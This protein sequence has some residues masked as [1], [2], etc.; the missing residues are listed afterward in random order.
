MINKM[1]YKNIIITITLALCVAS[2]SP[3]AAYSSELFMVVSDQSPLRD[4]SA[5]QVKKIFKLR[6]RMW[7]DGMPIQPINMVKEN[8]LRND[9]SQQILRK[10][11]AQ[12]E[13][14]YL[15]MA[16]TGRGQPPHTV[17][18]YDELVSFIRKHQG[19]I[20]YVNQPMNQEGV[21]TLVIKR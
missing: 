10:R 3:Q 18:D 11:P 21:K 7:S 15:K 17:H 14:Y 9:F 16:L 8:A 13:V 5:S 1:S 6:Q 20:G 4:I 2:W 12:M 19:A